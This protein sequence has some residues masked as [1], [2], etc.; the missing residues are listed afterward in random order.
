MDIES[1]HEGPYI[2]TNDKKVIG[3]IFI[4]SA[5]LPQKF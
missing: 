3:F 5:E 2:V 4:A 1:D